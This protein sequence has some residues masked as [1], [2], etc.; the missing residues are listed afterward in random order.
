M[1]N[2]NCFVNIDKEDF[3]LH[4]ITNYE[5]YNGYVNAYLRK[6]IN[7]KIQKLNLVYFPF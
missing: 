5:K 2:K 1:H 3:W 4:E 6:I 7:I